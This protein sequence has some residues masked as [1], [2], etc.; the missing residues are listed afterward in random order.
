MM[1]TGLVWIGTASLLGGV[2]LIAANLMMYVMGFSASYN[3]GDSSKD[4]FF[5]ISVWHIGIALAII[6]G[7]GLYI[8]KRI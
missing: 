8:G 1:R 3:I 5:L 6:G 7:G 2:L 4:Q